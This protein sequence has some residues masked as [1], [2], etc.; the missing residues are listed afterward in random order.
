MYLSLFI[1][2]RPPVF[3]N[4]FEN[5]TVVKEVMKE[6]FQSSLDLRIFW[7]PNSKL[8]IL[9]WVSLQISLIFAMKRKHIGSTWIFSLVEKVFQANP[10][11]TWGGDWIAC[12]T[13][14]RVTIDCWSRPFT[15]TVKKRLCLLREIVSEQRNR[16]SPLYRKSDHSE[17]QAY[18]AWTMDPFSLYIY[19][20]IN[21]NWVT[22]YI[23]I[24]QSLE[25]RYI[26][27]VIYAQHADGKSLV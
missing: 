26:V 24:E 10:F 21:G 18:C 3:A 20:I 27:H 14:C 16:T 22:M 4:Y 7:G 9:L 5:Y 2:N 19:S 6:M 25:L 8:N 1:L 11:A 23:F 13:R 17:Q 15:Y 12:V